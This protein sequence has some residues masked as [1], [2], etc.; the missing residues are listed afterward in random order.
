MT[1]AGCISRVIEDGSKFYN[2]PVESR[3]SHT[4]PDRA[5]V[6]YAFL[7]RNDLSAPPSSTDTYIVHV[8]L[9]TSHASIIDYIHHTHTYT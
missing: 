4:V 7:L 9:S 2:V 6:I 8:S 3:G 5:S 1:D